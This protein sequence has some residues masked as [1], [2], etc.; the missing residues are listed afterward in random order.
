MLDTLACLRNAS[1]YVIDGTVYGKNCG[2]IFDEDQ[3]LLRLVRR[4]SRAAA[5]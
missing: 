3:P 4:G 2:G 1:K 5:K